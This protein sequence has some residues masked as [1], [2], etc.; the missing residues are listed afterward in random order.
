MTKEWEEMIALERRYL[1]LET[2][3]RLILPKH[4]VSARGLKHSVGTIRQVNVR[5]CGFTDTS[6]YTVELE[7]RSKIEIPF[8]EA[9]F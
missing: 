3:T 2:G 8:N 1:Q 5:K 4:I 9:D 6:N 7:D